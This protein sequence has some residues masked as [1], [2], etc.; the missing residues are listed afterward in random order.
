MP[1]EVD[2][3]ETN[4][5]EAGSFCPLPPVLDLSPAERI[6]VFAPHPDDETLGCGGTISLLAARCPVKVVLVT[7]GSGVRLPPG[8][9]DIRQR[10]FREAL[11]ALGIGDM[12]SLG[13][14]DSTFADCSAFGALVGD[15]FAEFKPNWVFLPSPL[16][17]H[18]DHV[19]IS[20]ALVRSCQSFEGVTRML[21]YETWAPLPATHVVDITAAVELKRQALLRHETPMSRGDYVRA[22]DGLNR[23]RG[24]Y[25]GRQRF[26]EAFWVEPANA[27]SSLFTQLR[28]IGHTLRSRLIEGDKV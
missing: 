17:Y 24:L 14:P 28:G 13:Y 23:Y 1:N 4:E 20:N 11:S 15:I 22:I 10:E 8:A 19:R 12:R 5:A 16:D 18:R 6:V 9:S 26:A 2:P 27:P 21:F 25:L 3:E 7:D